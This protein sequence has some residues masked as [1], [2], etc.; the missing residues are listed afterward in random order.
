M[1]QKYMYLVSGC[2]LAITG[3]FKI[4]SSENMAVATQIL[5]NN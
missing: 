4:T 3:T 1:K 2:G 5:S